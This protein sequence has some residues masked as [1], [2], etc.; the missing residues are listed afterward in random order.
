MFHEKILYNLKKSGNISLLKYLQSQN[1]L[2]K[3]YIY[4]LINV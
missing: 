4:L 2:I 1:Y 3:L